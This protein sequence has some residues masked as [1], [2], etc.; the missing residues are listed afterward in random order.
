MA[1]FFI[2]AMTMTACKKKAETAATEGTPEAT[3][4]V[5]ELT[6]TPV[7]KLITIM[8]KGVDALKNNTE[9]AAA[10]SEL[11]SL[12]SS[13]NVADIFAEAKADKEAGNGATDEQKT[14]LSNLKAE[15][16]KLALELGKKDPAAFNAA[17][18]AFSKAFKIN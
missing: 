12:L 14:Q 15:Y 2:A 17:H 18:E 16:K 5:E 1:I 8:Q 13:Y 7:E 11:N 10:A 4:Q 3:A 9:P 6:G